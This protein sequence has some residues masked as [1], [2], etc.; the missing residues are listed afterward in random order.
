MKI[1]FIGDLHMDYNTHHNFLESFTQ[2]C[3]DLALDAIVFCGDTT[4]GAFGSLDFYDALSKETSTEVLE[5]PG[6]HELYCTAGRKKAN[7][8]EY[9]CFDAHEYMELMLSHPIESVRGR[10]G[11]GYKVADWY[12]PQQHT[13]C[14][15]QIRVLKIAASLVSAEDRCVIRT[16]LEQFAP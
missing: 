6:N 10:Y 5:I 12:S 3:N 2:I 11:G 13:L 15:E 7:Q 16:I 9:L 1:G 4:T 14:A 8:N